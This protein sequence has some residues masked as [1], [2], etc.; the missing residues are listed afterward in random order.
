MFSEL[1]LSLEAWIF[2]KYEFSIKIQEKME[3]RG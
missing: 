2:K 1:D 3:R